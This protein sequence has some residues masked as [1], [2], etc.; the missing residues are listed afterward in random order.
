MRQQIPEV[1]DPYVLEG[2]CHLQK[3]YIRGGLGFAVKVEVCCRHG[4]ATKGT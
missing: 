3:K 1:G 4:L 2:W